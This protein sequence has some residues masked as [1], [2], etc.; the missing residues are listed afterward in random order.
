MFLGVSQPEVPVALMA[1]TLLLANNFFSVITPQGS[2]ANV[3]F[4]GSGYLQRRVET[5]A[6][7]IDSLLERIDAREPDPS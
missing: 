3:I 5:Y 6:V 1:M 2:S 4:V 7:Q